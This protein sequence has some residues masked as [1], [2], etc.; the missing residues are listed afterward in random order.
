MAGEQF[1]GGF[2]CA[3]PSTKK[4]HAGIWKWGKPPDKIFMKSHNISPPN[5]VNWK[6]L[7]SIFWKQS[8]DKYTKWVEDDSI[9]NVELL[10]SGSN[11]NERTD[12]ESYRGYNQ[13]YDDKIDHETYA[14]MNSE[15]AARLNN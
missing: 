15:H 11:R 4:D 1:R 13:L 8:P 2:D 12:E 3:T 5:E 6:A 7:R 10:D 9:P 14:Q